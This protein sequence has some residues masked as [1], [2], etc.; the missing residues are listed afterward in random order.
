M[1][2]QNNSFSEIT[3]EIVKLASLSEKAGIIDTELFTK[4]DVKRG[5]RD[6]NG[7]GVLAGL[8]NISDVRANKIV[9]GVQVPTHGRLFYRGYDVKDL[10]EGF[11]NEN[12]FGFEEITYL[13]LFDRLPDRQELESFSR[14]LSSYR[15]LPTS[16][17]RDIIM[18]APSNDMMN[19]LARSVLTLYSY[20]ARSCPAPRISCTSFGRT[21]STRRWRRRFWISP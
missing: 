3:P 9:D 8:T 11:A 15:S 14:L 5:L 17:V 18:K 2:E 13:L 20:D 12:R 19:T 4:Y 21:A 16:F 10:V 1:I 6:L 7:K